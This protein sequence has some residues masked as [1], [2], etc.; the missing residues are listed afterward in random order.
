MILNIEIDVDEIRQRVTAATSM[1]VC[2][3]R[4]AVCALNLACALPRGF[5][6]TPSKQEVKAD[7]ILPSDFTPKVADATLPGACIDNSGCLFL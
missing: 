2:L 7:S 4:Y 1:S 3:F 6:M 5:H